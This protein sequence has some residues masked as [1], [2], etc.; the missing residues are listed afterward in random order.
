[1]RVPVSVLRVLL[2]IPW[3][4]VRKASGV[5]AIAV[6]RMFVVLVSQRLRVP[7]ERCARI[8]QEYL[9]VSNL[10]VALRILV[11]H[12]RRAACVVAVLACLRRAA[13]LFQA[14][15]VGQ[16]LRVRQASVSQRLAV[17]RRSMG[18]ALEWSPLHTATCV[19]S[20]WAARVRL[21]RAMLTLHW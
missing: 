12:V 5:M 6:K 3:V 16:A 20:V 18:R 10:L 4:L 13:W 1:M 9:A 7:L 2:N 15:R 8:A 17:Q 11:A 14:V 21:M 19:L